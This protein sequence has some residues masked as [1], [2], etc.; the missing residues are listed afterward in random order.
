MG[1]SKKI[2]IVED[3]ADIQMIEEA[4]LQAAGFQ[5]ETVADGT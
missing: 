1:Q 5:T 4:Y 2:L 3:D